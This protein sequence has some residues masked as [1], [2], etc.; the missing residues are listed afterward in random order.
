MTSKQG[1]G[2]QENTAGGSMIRKACVN[3]CKGV[4]AQIA[5]SREVILAEARATLKVQNQLLRL[6][7]NE[8]EALAWQ[9]LYPH[10]VFPALATEKVQRLAT[11]NKRQ[12]DLNGQTRTLPG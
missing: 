7:L 6:A 3:S 2:S 11:W 12:L 4:L 10:L 8:A 1:K 9:T 5:R